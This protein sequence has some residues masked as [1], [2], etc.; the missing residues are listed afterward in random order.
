MSPQQ[1]F[2]AFLCC[3]LYR[4][5]LSKQKIFEREEQ[6]VL[7]GDQGKNNVLFFVVG[8]IIVGYLNINILSKKDSLFLVV[9]RK[10]I[11]CFFLR[12]ALSL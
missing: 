3:W 5:G 12:L 11:M 9:I 8:F 2:F 6:L 4:C 1:V 10:K 7:I